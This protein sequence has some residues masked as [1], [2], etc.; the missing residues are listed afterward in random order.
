MNMISVGNTFTPINPVVQFAN[1]DGASGDLLQKIDRADFIGLPLNAPT[2]IP[3][4]VGVELNQ[5]RSELGDPT[6]V[7]VAFIPAVSFLNVRLDLGSGYRLTVDERDQSL[8][9]E[10]DFSEAR[11]VIWGN[12]RI[13]GNT[14]SEPLQFWG[15]T[16]FAF[17]DEGKI[18]LQTQPSILNPNVYSLE[19]VSISN[20]D[21]GIIIT[22]LANDTAGD[23]TID[24]SK[25]GEAIDDE[26]RDG[27]TL[28]EADQGRG[29]VDDNDNAMVQ[30]LMDATALGGT[31]GPG[32]QLMSRSEFGTL[33]AR[34]FSSWS[35]FYITSQTNRF[36]PIESSRPSE[37]RGDVEKSSQRKIIERLL[38]EQ[39]LIKANHI[40]RSIQTAL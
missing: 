20:G 6:T 27:F 23:L 5:F 3:P 29:W 17:G 4:I 25:S 7:P 32:S 31:F 28:Y 36:T 18:T 13:E 40:H 8:L 1:D 10:N 2:Q 16:S 30:Q 19:T 33:I 11:T 38:Q 39:A 35:L 22:G 9:F 37:S 21:R 14:V 34:F 24:R 26:A 12:A 15:T